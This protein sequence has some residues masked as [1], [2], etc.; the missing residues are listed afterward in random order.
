MNGIRFVTDDKG[1]RFAVQIDLKRYGPILE[2]IW[3][4]LISDSRR[5]EKAIPYEAY[6]AGRLKRRRT[7]NS[8]C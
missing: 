2:D 5:K 3:D 8:G 1:R 7:V 6:R 4:G